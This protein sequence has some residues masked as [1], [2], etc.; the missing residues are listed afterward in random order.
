MFHGGKFLNFRTV[1]FYFTVFSIGSRSE[2]AKMIIFYIK[3]NCGFDEK[4]EKNL[5]GMD[6]I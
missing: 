2:H 3:K 4:N 5:G 6:E 1:H